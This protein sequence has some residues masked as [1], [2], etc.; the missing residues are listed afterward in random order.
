M[1]AAVSSWS[2]VDE[3][4]SP[5]RKLLAPQSTTPTAVMAVYIGSSPSWAHGSWTAATAGVTTRG[6]AN[7][8]SRG[9]LGSPSV[10]CSFQIV[11]L[12]RA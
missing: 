5:M 11:N 1:V 2:I 12:P 7:E 6:L 8:T 4:E 9:A 3:A 10:I